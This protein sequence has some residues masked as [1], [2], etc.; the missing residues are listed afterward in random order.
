MLQ[1]SILQSSRIKYLADM[2][3]FV[4]PGLEA[5]IKE[6]FYFVKKKQLE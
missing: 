5:R 2:R 1:K 3:D 6:L 4:I